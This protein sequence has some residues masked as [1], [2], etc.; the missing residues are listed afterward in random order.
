MFTPADEA[1][2]VQPIT[3]AIL[4]GN[5]SSLKGQCEEALSKDEQLY[6]SG[7]VSIV[8]E[9]LTARNSTYSLRDL[10]DYPTNRPG[11][12]ASDFELDE[13]VNGETRR[14]NKFNVDWKMV[15]GPKTPDE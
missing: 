1:R 15:S 3:D 12:R 6:A 5:F 8:N 10:V 2:L 9:Q 14:V 11:W 4:S 7:L 13:N